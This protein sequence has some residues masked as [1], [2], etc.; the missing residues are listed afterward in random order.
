MREPLGSWPD[1]KQILTNDINND[2][3][4]DLAIVGTKQVTF[5]WGQLTAGPGIDLSGWEL[6]AAALVDYDNDGW[7]DFCARGRSPTQ[8][9][10]GQ[11]R[12]W[13]SSHAQAW[14]EVTTDCGLAAQKLP[15]LADLLAADLDADEDTDLLL[16]TADGE[17]RFLRNHGGHVN[18]QLKVRLLSL[19]AGNRGGIGTQLEVRDADY[20]ATRWV[21]RE[22]PIEIGLNGRHELDTV[23]TVWTD[24][25][26][27]SQ[28]MVAPTGRPLD[29]IVSEV[30]STGS[31]PYLYVWDGRGLRFV[32]DLLGGG[33]LG[34]PISRETLEPVNPHETVVI[35][36]SDHFRPIG[37]SYMLKIANEQR[38]VDYLD[39]FQLLAV[40]HPRQVEVHSS[41]RL[42]GPSH[43]SPEV[44]GICRLTRPVRVEGDDG[45][46]RTEHVQEIDGIFAPPGPVLPPPLRGVC[47]PLS[48][49]LDFGP[50]A[51]ER[52]LLLALTGWV[53]YGTSSSNIAL[54][55]NRSIRVIR[56]VLEVE[57][58]DGDWEVLG[59][60][61]GLPAGKTKTIL[62]DLDGKLPPGARKLRLTTTCEVRWDR[63]AS[64]NLGM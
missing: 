37:D 8:P 46:D 22:W 35:G 64:A 10:I 33:A 52:P 25:I 40:D 23:R 2:G 36:D 49:T 26:V 9:G 42:G 62:Y 59:I 11:I 15:P 32:T 3:G 6:Q 18:G 60:D 48:L 29:F 39:Y 57:T 34:V 14:S 5:V 47:Q 44:R 19:L 28:T 53:Q 50:M 61:V 51:T 41:S 1:A 12:L 54:S 24:G 17:L 30:I 13:R 21:Q 20:S 16:V 31:C 43:Q 58:G 38:E 4:P 63:I 55:Q 56:P 7:L 27:R 45:I